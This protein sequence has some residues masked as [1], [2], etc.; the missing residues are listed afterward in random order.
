[1]A[2]LQRVGDLDRCLDRSARASRPARVPPSSTPRRAASAG[3][4]RSAPPPSFFRH[5]GSRKIV[6]AVDERR[7][8]AE[9]TN[10]NS[11]VGGNVPRQRRRAPRAARDHEVDLA[12]GRVEA[13]PGLVVVVDGEH[14]AGRVGE[15]RVE[16][17]VAVGVTRALHRLGVGQEARL[18]E[19]PH[20]GGAFAALAQRRAERLVEH[21]RSESARGAAARPSPSGTRRRTRRGPSRGGRVQPG[22]VVVGVARRARAPAGG[23]SRARAACPAAGRRSARGAGSTLSGNSSVKN[24]ASHFSYCDA[25]GS[26]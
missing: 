4:M 23:G 9:S 1:M 14:D 24:V 7:S 16:E 26:T 20:R 15:H 8:P 12:V 11:S 5:A 17:R 13:L 6:F 21:D 10:G 19:A 3:L 2:R 22:E 25:A 18:R